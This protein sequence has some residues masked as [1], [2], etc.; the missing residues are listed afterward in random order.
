MPFLV[1]P[2]TTFSM[3]PKRRRY[4]LEPVAGK[5]DEGA[6]IIEQLAALQD[7]LGDLHEVHVFSEQV[8]SFAAKAAAEQALRLSEAVMEDAPE[9]R[10]RRER[11][12]DPGPGLLALARLLHQRSF[13]AFEVIR[14]DWLGE[15]SAPFFARVQALAADLEGARDS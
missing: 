8:A 12:A 15:A 2:T 14:S 13:G 3:S 7:V 1:A 11:S 10:L 9:S 4:L 6:T 5:G